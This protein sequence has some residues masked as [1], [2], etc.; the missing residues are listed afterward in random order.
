[1]R[2]R[3]RK[4]IPILILTMVASLFGEVYQATPSSAK[5]EV[6]EVGSWAELQEKIDATE[7]KDIIYQLTDDINATE[8]DS[9]I[10]ISVGML[11]TIDLNGKTINRN[12][13][14]AA[15]DGYAI[16][17][18]EKEKLT[19]VDSSEDHDG[20]ITGG[21]NTGNG[22]GFCVG[23]GAT[24]S[25]EDV[26]VTGNT[27]KCGG[28]I[29]LEDGAS[30]I[31]KN[32]S[33]TENTA[34]TTGGGIASDG[35]QI[36]FAGGAIAIK[37]NTASG[38]DDDGI[39]FINFN[40]MEVTGKFSKNSRIVFALP[41]FF[42]VLTNG[43][44]ENNSVEPSYYF[45]Y[46]S[47]DD[48]YK[49]TDSSDD[50]EVKL[51]KN[52]E[53]IKNKKD[54]T[55]EILGSNGNIKEEKDFTNFGLAWKYAS[56]KLLGSCK[57]VI[58][59]GE[60]VNTTGMMTVAPGTD[61]VLDLN[62][63]CINR[64]LTEPEDDGA[65]IFVDKMGTL[66]IKDSNPK[67]AGYDGVR[68]G[69]IT[70]GFG[71]DT[72]GG[73]QIEEGGNVTMKGGTIYNCVTNEDGGAVRIVGDVDEREKT[74]FIMTGGTISS[75]HTLDSADSCYG[76]AIFAKGA[77]LDIRNATFKYNY[78]EDDGGAISVEKCKIMLDKTVFSENK[79]TNDGGA[80]SVRYTK[81]TTGTEFTA[82]D[83]KFV[84]N[85]ATDSGGALYIG[86]NAANSVATMIHQCEFR[87]NDSDKNGG[88]ISVCDDAVA[89]SEVKITDNYAKKNGGGVFVDARYNLA[90]KGKVVIRDNSCG[91]ALGA[92][93]CLEEGTL[94]KAYVIDCGLTDGSYIGVGSTSDSD[95]VCI[96]ENISK[97]H[98]KYFHVQSGN[99]KMSQERE[100]KFAL[101]MSA[102]LISDGYVK[103]III[104]AVIGLLMVIAAWY[105]S[106]R[107]RRAKQ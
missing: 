62:G 6:V 59:L 51:V 4:M 41:E 20:K 70:G 83:C 57:A 85:H 35:G 15:D 60:D 9:A 17:M 103:A 36:I 12:I 53:K 64:G 40:K 39:Y 42:E 88:A 38:D 73:I 44:G 11:I 13:T 79:A 32:T 29:Y 45:V 69:V 78:C 48:K 2:K 23:K 96:S 105:V 55:V 91:R 77:T 90:L 7:S 28:G 19:I 58:T 75:C 3:F 18:E 54:H 24:L 31:M 5:T 30:V 27:A 49:V 21:N 84:G 101:S 104:M 107:R 100:Q 95:K 76:G 98:L 65:V 97:F 106:G 86:D 81:S 82:R 10:H 68:G 71:N 1:M 25:L 50:S 47:S 102:S 8:E 74:T 99:L 56:N 61:I 52:M 87:E 16:V 67:S 46:K 89:L 94:S 34:E 93:L 26:K 33:I 72:A 63:H 92:D 22:G 80:V 37:N 66:L 43:Y 14:E